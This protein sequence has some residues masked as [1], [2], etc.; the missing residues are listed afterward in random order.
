MICI[1]ALGNET[2]KYKL[3]CDN[4]V[5]NDAKGYL[6][7]VR[8]TLNFC[9]MITSLSISRSKGACIDADADSEYLHTLAYSLFANE[10]I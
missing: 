5:F 7:L 2:E 10:I 9:Y 8:R 6:Y 1:F 4:I 3:W